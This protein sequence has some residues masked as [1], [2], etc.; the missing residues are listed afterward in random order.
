MLE[1]DHEEKLTKA[2]QVIKNI[3]WF[4]SIGKPIDELNA[5][6][7]SWEEA[8]ERCNESAW[9]DVL[10]ITHNELGEFVIPHLED[11][12][13]TWN[14]VAVEIR[15]T[16]LPLLDSVIQDHITSHNVSKSVV[17]SFTWTILHIVMSAY[18]ED[19]H[20]FSFYTDLARWYVKG[21]FPCGWEGQYPEGQ[22]IVY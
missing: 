18:Y 1:T 16:V 10:I 11:R 22:L 2:L 6:V 17:D 9:Q 14:A 12:A 19:M 5:H 4:A 13:N 20:Q 15:K 7:G 8:D 21:H 3:N